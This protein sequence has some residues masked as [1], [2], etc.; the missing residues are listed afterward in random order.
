MAVYKNAIFKFGGN[1]LS[2]YVRSI[3]FAHEAEE[4]DDT[5]MGDDTRSAE[6]GLQMWS[7]EGTMT[8]EFGTGAK[9]DATFATRIGTTDSVVFWPG[10]T[11]T[12]TPSDTAPKYSGTG[13]L[14][15][16]SPQAN[17]SV[18]DRSECSFSIVAAGTLTRSVT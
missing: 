2:T 4:L 15:S 10:A 14:T 9:P 1:A 3:A 16:Y 11:A 13:L 7:I 18:G 17:E 6:G 8:Q 12:T 5:V